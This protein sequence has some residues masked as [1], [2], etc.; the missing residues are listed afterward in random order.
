MGLLKSR[1]LL[2]SSAVQKPDRTQN[3]LYRATEMH[4]QIQTS[5]DNWSFRSWCDLLR[6]PFPLSSAT[7]SD[8]TKETVR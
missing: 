2:H 3:P 6:N 5:I 4:V 7:D 1:V 8:S